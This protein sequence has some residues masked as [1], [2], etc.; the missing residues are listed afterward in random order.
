MRMQV[1]SLASLSGLK[2]PALPRA[3]EYVEGEA[4]IWRCCGCGV[5]QQLQLQFDP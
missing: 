3:V 4:W 2:E 5:D 1:S